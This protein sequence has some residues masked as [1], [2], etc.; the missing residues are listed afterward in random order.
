MDNLNSI[1]LPPTS[2]IPL[3]RDSEPKLVITSSTSGERSVSTVSG[4]TEEN[5]AKSSHKEKKKHKKEKHKHK[6]KHKEKSKDK[7][8]SHQMITQEVLSQHASAIKAAMLKEVQSDSKD[9]DLSQTIVDDL[10]KDFLATKMNEIESAYKQ[11][12]EKKDSENEVANSVD[13]MNRLLDDELYSIN[14]NT[15]SPVKKSA[16]S[17]RSHDKKSSKSDSL[18]CE[19]KSSVTSVQTNLPDKLPYTESSKTLDKKPS[20]EKK[21]SIL[22]SSKFS[23]SS[24][25]KQVKTEDVPKTD[26]QNNEKVQN[27]IIKLPAKDLSQEKNSLFDQVEGS[28]IKETSVKKEEGASLEPGKGVPFESKKPGK[29][30]LAFKI[31]QTSAELISSGAKQDDTLAVPKKNL[32]EGEVI[33]S[34]HGSSSDSDSDEKGDVEDDDADISE[35]GSL[36]DSDKETKDK[37]KK[38]KKKKKHKKKKK[39]HK[40]SKEKD[41]ELTESKSK[42]KHS[43]QRSTSRSKSPKKHKKSQSP[44]KETTRRARSRSFSPGHGVWRDRSRSK[45]RKKKER[46]RSFSPSH[47]V[48]RSNKHKHERERSRE[49]ETDRKH[50]YEKDRDYD[51]HKHDRHHDRDK[52]DKDYDSHRDRE[53]HRSR[54]RENEKRDSE[55]R[56]GK[57]RSRSRSKERKGDKSKSNEDLRLKIDKAKLREIA[58]KNAL[59]MAKAGSTVPGVD[60]ASIKAGGKSIDELTE[61][62]ARIASKEKL[63]HRPAGLTSSSSSDEDGKKSDEDEDSLIHHPFKVNEKSITLN[64]RNAVPLP[65]LNAQEKITQQ[66]TLRLQFPVDSGNVHR[67]KELEWVPVQKTETVKTSVVAVTTNAVALPS[68]TPSGGTTTTTVTAVVP[69]VSTEVKLMPV[70]DEDKVFVETQVQETPVDIRSIIS[71]RI[72]AARKLAEN[73]K[74]LAA[75]SAMQKAQHNASLWA[76]SKNLPGKFIGS[77][78][79]QILSQEE[80]MGP[81]KKRQ[82]WAKKDQFNRAAPVKGGIGMALLQKMGWQQGTGLGKNNEGGLEPLALDFKMDR[83]GLSSQDEYRPSKKVYL[84]APVKKDLSG[85]HPVSALVELCNKRRWGSPDFQMVHEG[86][87][88][89]KKNF[90]FKVIVN[91]V[92][93]QPSVASQNKKNA[94]AAAAT[95]VLQ[96][97]GL[98]PR[99]T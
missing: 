18:A 37:S 5:G 15:P 64:I 51:R 21:L 42:R 40:I 32:E 62:C 35:T 10:F 77:T 22:E 31:S 69:T 52:H 29:F 45:D 26:I 61:F 30:Q 8:K 48:W 79:A 1:P 95:A 28:V 24:A 98:V 16:H 70:R 11:A 39:K 23:I 33:S 59:A 93:Y 7:K 72:K 75:M 96:E 58:M 84:N 76:N 27:H 17:K 44:S 38:K 99:D 86:G 20:D 46:S 13:E 97:M 56:Y 43:S 89:H 90:L 25:V 63:K 14:Q 91:G 80:L 36:S 50:D 92:E 74:D 2:T 41:K 65:I 82:A 78:G 81:D 88:D 47:G 6:H 73:P 54:D 12:A 68:T 9:G 94:K 53:R 34:G 49:R 71:E 67:T 83:K 55:R 85:K 87:P 4:D 60:F 57:W 19:V 66:A 3:P